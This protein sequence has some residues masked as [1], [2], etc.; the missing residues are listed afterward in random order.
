MFRAHHGEG[1]TT[2]ASHKEFESA[3]ATK[4]LAVLVSFVLVCR[5]EPATRTAEL[6]AEPGGRGPGLR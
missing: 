4:Q 2:L 5:S 3:E 1:E 6:E